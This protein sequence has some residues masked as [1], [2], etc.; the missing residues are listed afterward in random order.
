MYTYVI[1]CT[2]CVR[3][4]KEEDSR[5]LSESVASRVSQR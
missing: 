2:I 3:D 4:D 5:A 1:V